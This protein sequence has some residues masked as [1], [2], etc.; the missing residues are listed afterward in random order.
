M[1]DYVFVY[2]VD[3]Y[4]FIAFPLSAPLKIG[5]GPC[6]KILQTAGLTGFEIGKTKVRIGL[7]FN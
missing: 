6:K 4:K 2:F 7:I 5:P 1:F 3:R